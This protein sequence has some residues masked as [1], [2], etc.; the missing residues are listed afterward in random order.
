MNRLYSC[1]NF[2]LVR[3][4]TYL[5]YGSNTLTI[6]SSRCVVYLLRVSG[7]VSWSGL[8]YRGLMRR[9]L[10]SVRVLRFPLCV[11]VSRAVCC[12][13]VSFIWGVARWRGVVV[14]F[15]CSTVNGEVE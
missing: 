8:I 12:C 7:E 9:L 14:L 10:S 6:P 1:E 3:L 11:L 13:V 2:S 4:P 5:P 15:A